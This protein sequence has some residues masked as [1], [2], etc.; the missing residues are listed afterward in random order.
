MVS[1]YTRFWL[2]PSTKGRFVSLV[3]ELLWAMSKESDFVSAV[4]SDDEATNDEVILFEVW[5]GTKEKWLSEQPSKPYRLNHDAAVEGFL[6]KK[7]V[8]LLTPLVIQN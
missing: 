3:S 2:L 7:E 4:L 8:C 5:N 6:I 1:L